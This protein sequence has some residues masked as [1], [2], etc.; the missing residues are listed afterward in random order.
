MD[1]GVRRPSV[2]DWGVAYACWLHNCGSI[3][4][5]ADN[6]MDAASLRHAPLPISNHFHGCTARL[7][8]VKWRYIKYK[9]FTFL[10]LW[11]IGTAVRISTHGLS[12]LKRR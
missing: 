10:L 8:F 5:C 9:G 7:R 11:V 4:R 3:V 6:G 2:V 12:G 1:Y